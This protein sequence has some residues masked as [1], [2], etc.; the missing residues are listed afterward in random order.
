M[1]TAVGSCTWHC[2]SSHGKVLLLLHNPP[3]HLP[4][5]TKKILLFLVPFPSVLIL[6]A[7]LGLSHEFHQPAPA[8]PEHVQMSAMECQSLVARRCRPSET[9]HHP[10]HP[11]DPLVCCH[12]SFN[13]SRDPLSDSL[14]PILSPMTVIS[15]SPARPELS[16]DVQKR[17]TRYYRQTKRDTGPSL[18]LGL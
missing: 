8:S 13:H 4:R 10:S 2:I 11:L 6:W 16:R 9:G 14:F 18:S 1:T 17:E 5:V 12:L 7:F 3:I 15:T